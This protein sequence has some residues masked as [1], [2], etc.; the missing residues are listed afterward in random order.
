MKKDY[1]KLAE[2]ARDE[3]LADFLADFLFGKKLKK[4]VTES[5]S[6]FK[7]AKLY[8]LDLGRLARDKGYVTDDP[9]SPKASP[10]RFYS[11][12]APMESNTILEKVT[13]SEYDNGDCTISYTNHDVDIKDVS[14]DWLYIMMD[15]LQKMIDE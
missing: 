12:Y 1:K 3:L 7:K 5:Y 14:I 15:D 13:Y 9:D 2:R 4:Y 10:I 6:S 11:R 8:T